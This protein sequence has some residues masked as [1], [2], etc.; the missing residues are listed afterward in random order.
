MLLVLLTWAGYIALFIALGSPIALAAS[1]GRVSL[2]TLRTSMW[3]GVVAFV[4][5]AVLV[6]FFLP[7]GSPIALVVE[8]LASVLAAWAAVLLWQRGGRR[9]SRHWRA[10][11]HPWHQGSAMVAVAAVA[12]SAARS[13]MGPVTAFDTGLYHLSSIGYAAQYRTIPGLANL[14]FTLGYHDS[15]FTFAAALTNG[16]WSA[17][18]WRLANGLLVV[19]LGIEVAV[20]TL[21]RRANPSLYV[22]ALSLLVVAAI[23]LPQADAW[24][25]SPTP[26]TATMIA[27]LVALTYGVDA[28]VASHRHQLAIATMLVVGAWAVTMRPTMAVFVGVLAVVLVVR[29][30]RRGGR[31][32]WPPHGIAWFTGALIAV[33]FILQLTRDALTSGWLLYPASL[34]RLPFDWTTADPTPARLLS[35]GYNRVGPVAEAYTGAP[36]FGWLGPWLTTYLPANRGTLALLAALGIVAV[37]TGLLALG[38][39]RSAGTSIRGSVLLAFLAW[40]AG[41]IAV[42]T[43]LL[44]GPP[45]IRFVWGPLFATAII[46]AAWALHAWL[47]RTRWA[48]V[49]RMAWM[50]WSLLIVTIAAISVMHAAS[51]PASLPPVPTRSETLPSGVTITVPTNPGMQCW[52]TFPLCTP[53]WAP[54]LA[55]RGRSVQD[56]FSARGN[57]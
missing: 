13:T 28:L 38:R 8:V 25:A 36:G 1:S 35:I 52:A 53:E 4:C 17:D 10:R 50:A 2:P 12:V 32:V 40:I 44:F 34:V 57:P 45:A 49:G 16:L 18:G 29:E 55:M 27:C 51:G 54:E 37:V 5:I 24:I 9:T 56:G 30:W 20:R 11:V 22:A 47:R 14:Y 43:G 39:A 19:M 41:P 6:N 15:F 42:V 48:W 23:V 31:P 46:P 26:D 33:L 3:L 21:Q 7:L